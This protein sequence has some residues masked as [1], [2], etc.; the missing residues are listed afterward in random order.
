MQPKIFAKQNTRNI[1]ALQKN[2]C[3]AKLP[4]TIHNKR[5]S[6]EAHNNLRWLFFSHSSP[7]WLFWWSTFFSSHLSHHR[8]QHFISQPNYFIFLLLVDFYWPPLSS[9]ILASI[10]VVDFIIKSKINSVLT[11]NSLV[12]SSPRFI[13]AT[14]ATDQMQSFRLA[15]TQT[16]H[17]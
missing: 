9:L 13:H 2:G 4:A 17:F 7:F 6:R 12:H 1:F 14:V 15:R 5:S 11:L 8:M 16:K 3:C 10:F